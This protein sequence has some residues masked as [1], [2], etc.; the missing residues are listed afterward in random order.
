MVRTW[1]LNSSMK[2]APRPIPYTV[3]KM[4]K[5]RTIKEDPNR[6]G[7]ANTLNAEVQEVPRAPQTDLRANPAGRKSYAA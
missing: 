1:I 7:G 6:R 3:H 4:F 5:M 2:K